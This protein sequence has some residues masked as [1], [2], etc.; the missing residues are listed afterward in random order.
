MTI[1]ATAE[2][3]LK[4]VCAA[5]NLNP[6][7]KA[8]SSFLRLALNDGLKWPPESRQKC[9]EFKL[10]LHTQLDGAAPLVDGGPL[11]GQ[12]RALA[13]RSEPLMRPRAE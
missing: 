12:G 1:V 2:M 7:I 13:R 4:Q 10:S 11:P 6:R 3:I 9:S 8:R 5:I